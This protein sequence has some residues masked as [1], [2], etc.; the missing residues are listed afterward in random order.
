MFV[1]VFKFILHRH[2]LICFKTTVNSSTTL[3]PLKWHLQET[4]T[5]LLCSLREVWFQQGEDLS[6]ISVEMSWL[7]CGVQRCFTPAGRTWRLHSKPQRRSKRSVLHCYRIHVRS[8]VSLSFCFPSGHG[9]CTWRVNDVTPSVAPPIP[10][11][12]SPRASPPG[13]SVF[14]LFQSQSILRVWLTGI[15]VLGRGLRLRWRTVL[16][17]RPYG[18][19]LLSK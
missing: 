19:S 14:F 6:Y 10:P 13:L 12:P 2:F 15:P 4:S 18:C 16:L 8:F 17:T 7:V 5:E 1:T 9:L 11:P 3:E